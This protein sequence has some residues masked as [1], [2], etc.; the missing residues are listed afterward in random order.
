MFCRKCG[1][2]IRDNSLVCERCGA[3]ASRGRTEEPTQQPV[4]TYS[5]TY[6]KPEP[7]FRKTWFIVIMLILFWPVGLIL[8][9]VFKKPGNIN[10]RVA[11]TAIVLIV[12]I[13][14]GQNSNTTTSENATRS[15]PVEQND[16]SA[17]TSV[18]EKD[19]GIDES[20]LTIG[21]TAQYSDYEL[22][23][24]GIEPYD[25][26]CRALY[27]IEALG[28]A[29]I[30]RNWFEGR[31]FQ[32]KPLNIDELSNSLESSFP[33]TIE[34]S[35]GD[36]VSGY[37]Y[38]LGEGLSSIRFSGGI[39]DSDRI[40][41]F[42]YDEKQRDEFLSRNYVNSLGKYGFSPE[43]SEAIR[44]LFDE[45]GIEGCSIELSE[46]LLGTGI[47]ELQSFR[48]WIDVHPDTSSGFYENSSRHQI[49][50]TIENRQV[51]F[52]EI[53]NFK[54]TGNPEKSSYVLYDTEQGGHL[55]YYNSTTD[56]VES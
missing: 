20:K 27:R 33:D 22:T 14:A 45:L 2:Q 52:V 36:T 47:D 13:V 29:N 10:L 37:V 40:W 44:Q 15:D 48:T 55:A 28:S 32:N 8:M 54:T 38:F 35:K 56:S 39:F 31:S 51:L 26:G 12:F 6:T 18:E 30:K 5:L 9:W 4:N 11:L 50:F 46:A 25:A 42:D 49:N 1:S 34:L 43:E 53:T 24:V 16:N 19:Y 21:Q 3:P 23:L 41:N 7:F 17:V